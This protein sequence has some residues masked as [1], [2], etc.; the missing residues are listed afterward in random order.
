MNRDDVNDGE[1]AERLRQLAR[2]VIV[3]PVDSRREARLLAAFDAVQQTTMSGRAWWW[4]VSLATAASLLVASALMSV[5]PVHRG[6]VGSAVDPASTPAAVGEFVA[7]PG[8]SSLPPLESGEL[9]RVQLPVSILPSL[10]LMPP[11]TRVTSVRA[12]VLVGQD[13]LT[14]A[15]R[16]V[17]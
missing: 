7:W 4:M 8:A 13:G 12:D 15:V 3:P 17:D 16:L 6:T 2:A 14:R 10:G 11:S 5:P 1:L 9:L